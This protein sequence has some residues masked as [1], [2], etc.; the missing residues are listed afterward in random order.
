[1]KFEI[2]L[3]R[4]D[5]IVPVFVGGGTLAVKIEGSLHEGFLIDALCNIWEQIGDENLIEFMS[6][7]G[8]DVKRSESNDNS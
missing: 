3:E 7:E 5:S 4:I 8:F 2:T 1:M 6:R